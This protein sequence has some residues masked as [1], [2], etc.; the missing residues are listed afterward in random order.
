MKYWKRILLLA[1]A[2]LL[3]TAGLS[4]CAHKEPETSSSALVSEPED[5]TV[6]PEGTSIGGKSISG[7]TVEEA[8]KICRD[9]I[10]ENLKTLEITVRF[11]D[12]TISLAKED[13]Q[14][15]E[16]LELT[17][18]KLLESRK[19]DD[20]ELSYVTDLSESGKQKLEEAAKACFTKGQ[21]AAVSGF[22]T[23]SGAFTFTDE[24]KG[25][26]V[27][28]VTTLKSVRQL[29]SQKHGGAIQAAFLETQ[30]AVTKQY[31][32]ENFK[33]M[34]SYTTE[35][36]NTANGN[37]NM[38]LALSYV[39][40]TILQPGQTFSYNST[41]GDST[42]PSAGWLPAG[43]LVSGISVQVYGGGIC[44]GSTTLYNAALLAGMEIVARECHSLPSSYCPIG[45]DATV[46]YGN[47][48]FQFKNPLSSPVYIAAWMDGV[49]LHVNFYGCFPKEWDKIT[50]GS[51]QTG[52]EPPL[53][54]VS[55]TE[56]VNLAK[57]QYVR[58][59]SGNTGYSACAW[60]TYYKGETKVKTE[61]LPSSY[62][63]PTGMVYAV[64]EGTDTSKVD[65]TKESGTVEPEATPTPEPTPT[66][67][68]SSNPEPPVSSDPE[69]TPDVTPEPGPSSE[70]PESS[71][72]VDWS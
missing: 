67:A 64:G 39:N 28:L 55:F 36:T 32:S 60:R 49:T 40:G 46:D 22:D 68:P 50:V 30:P 33:L 29:L 31:L 10:D 53:S 45:L 18:P 23:S 2:S 26:R 27:D 8:L 63:E 7:K 3:L 62:Y 1:A 61:E 15:K 70:D 65:T 38:A 24:Q 20:Y 17:L 4:A 44:Q 11:K 19:A 43:G 72:L 41:I 16:V 21:D 25:S 66:P 34:S 69:P 35:S 48:D 52:S 51:E 6:F 57:G 47:I 71:E 12:D 59:S 37:S 54:G 5:L 9:A 42:D 58:R 13:F 56:D 14:V